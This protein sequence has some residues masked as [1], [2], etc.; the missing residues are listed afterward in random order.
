MTGFSWC[1]LATSF[2]C[3][4]TSL[5]AGVLPDG[6]PIGNVPLSTKT[7]I[8]VKALTVSPI[9]SAAMELEEDPSHQTAV[10]DAPDAKL[11]AFAMLLFTGFLAALKRRRVPSPARERHYL[12]AIASVLWRS[13]LRREYDQAMCAVKTLLT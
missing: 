7:V 12:R 13:E 4:A 11:L 5:G 2:L 8:G 3:V 6:A 1:L 9:L 10:D